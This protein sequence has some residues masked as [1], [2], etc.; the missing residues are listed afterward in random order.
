MIDGRQRCDA[1]LTLLLLPTAIDDENKRLDV[2]NLTCITLGS[3]PRPT[4]LEVVQESKADHHG[5]RT[6]A[7]K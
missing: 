7:K 2:I 1:L 5:G 6:E 3:L 4:V